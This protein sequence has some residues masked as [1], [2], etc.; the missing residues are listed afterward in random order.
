VNE[1]GTLQLGLPLTIAVLARLCARGGGC[2]S[3]RTG[4]S[5]RSVR[6]SRCA[7]AWGSDLVHGLFPPFRLPPRIGLRRQFC[8]RQAIEIA[9]E[10]GVEPAR[11]PGSDCGEE[12]DTALCRGHFRFAD[13]QCVLWLRMDGAVEELYDLRIL[14]SCERPMAIGFQIDEIRRMLRL[15]PREAARERDEALHRD[16]CLNL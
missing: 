3:A 11:P 7:I 13:R 14:P 10:S 1:L 4:G 15:P 9:Q 6:S 16:D 8:G 5:W 2:V 12:G